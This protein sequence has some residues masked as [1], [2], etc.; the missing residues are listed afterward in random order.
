ML[1]QKKQGNGKMSI[2]AQ[3]KLARDA[4][5]KLAVL[6]TNVKNKALL[7]I[8][9]AIKKNSKAIIEANKRT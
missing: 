2:E 7:A 1:Q 9:N 6:P 4:S 8:A 5:I 3:A